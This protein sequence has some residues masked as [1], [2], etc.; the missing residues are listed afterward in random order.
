MPVGHLYV[1]FVKMSIQV[2]CPF[3]LDF[4]GLFLCVCV[5]GFLATKL[6]GFPVYVEMLPLVRYM[7]Y[8]YFLSFY[9][10]PFHFAEC[11]F[12]CSEETF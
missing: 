10:L 1:F 8:K 11:S 7:I 3:K 9:E 5:C 4:F 12:C 2:I 6:Y